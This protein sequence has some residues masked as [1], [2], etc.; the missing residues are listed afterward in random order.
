MLERDAQRTR[1]M[2]VGMLMRAYRES[3]ASP[4]GGRGLTQD[5]LLRRMAAVDSNYGQRYSHT[6]VSRW[7]S[8]ATRPS[9]ERLDV[10]GRALN[11]SRSEIE[12]IV[13]LAGLAAVQNDPH[14]NDEDLD[15]RPDDSDAHDSDAHDSA[16]TEA[17]SAALHNP[18][19]P[20]RQRQ[21]AN[22]LLNARRG[23][24]S[25][26]LPGSVIIGG[27]YLLASLGWNAVWMPI[28][29]IGLVVCFRLAASFQMFDG[30]HD[31]CEFFCVSLFVLLTTP[32]LQSAALNMDHYGFYA[33]RD[34]AGT[35][36]P[37]MFALLV[38]LALST[39]AGAMFIVLWKRQ[40]GS[41]ARGGN[42]VRRA[43]SVVLP[44]MACVY[45][46]VAV[47]TNFAILIQLG[48]V[49]AFFAAAC[50]VLLLLRDPTTNPRENDRR[51]LLWGLLVVAAVTSTIGAGAMLAVFFTPNLPAVFPDHNLLYSWDVDYNVL[52]F[53]QEEAMARFNMGYLWH[54]TSIFVYMVFVVGGKLLSAAYRWESALPT[55]PADNA[56][57]SSPGGASDPST[58]RGADGSLFGFARWPFR[59]SRGGPD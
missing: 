48:V 38:N 5:E 23:F 27:A 37:Y 41:G 29:Y 26:L 58:T 31:L 14:P 4:D 21:V 20:T 45:I 8:G 28:A 57:A 35:P 30:A 40:Y 7:E 33:I 18:A 10:F 9:R 43:V 24:F 19:V 32:L 53:S 51:F 13:T 56:P 3:F 44:P 2:Q 50:I 6:T 42:A 11:L 12:G 52:G 49:F 39:T 36:K 25:C 17:A 16:G 54:A 22:I 1:A 46:V 15:A 47:I 34:W 55:K 59:R